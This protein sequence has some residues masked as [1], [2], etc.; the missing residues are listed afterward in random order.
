MDYVYKIGIVGLGYVGLPLALSLS[1]KFKTIGYDINKLR[2][3][4]LKKGQDLTD[5]VKKEEI[6]S[7]VDLSLT[8]KISDLKKCNFFIITVPTPV[9]TFNNPDL[10][11]L[12]NASEEVGKF[13]LKKNDVVVYESTVFPGAT[14]EICAPI[15][16]KFS[17]LK[18]NKDFMVGY[19][20]ERINPGD[21][22]R[23]LENIIKIV[24][25]SNKKAL[26]IIDNVYSS[27]IEAGT[28]RVDLIKEAEA[29]KVIE[30]TQRDINIALFNELAIL[31]R[32]MNLNSKNIFDAASSKW[33]FLRFYPGLV[34]GHCIGV[35]PY[36]L[37]H[38]AKEYNF[39]PSLILAGRKINDFM[40]NHI[41]SEVLSLLIKK[42]I[43][44]NKDSKILIFG[45][46][47]KENCPDY[48]N[49]KVF[50]I[51]NLFKSLG[52]KIDIYDPVIKENSIFHDL[53][54]YNL[55]KK[56]KEKNY[57]ALIICVNHDFFKNMGFAFIKRFMK[58]KSVI[59]DVKRCFESNEIDGYLWWY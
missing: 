38:K 3:S 58:K 52:V 23:K 15:L 40:P 49:S 24:S 53:K 22:D 50:D 7:N 20:P 17:K 9:D 16:E 34:G 39:H 4:D 32:K 46:T 26:S 10:S 35:D 42:N 13:C 48:R 19:S 27:I 12:V 36:Y 59:Y 11:P 54:K 33:N 45:L 6:K 1:K 41:Y 30:N 43:A 29:A 31:F 47:F 55:I 51:V 44:V 56:P 57:D 18:L 37:T 2:I 14:E 5:E 8:H 21:K 25:G 28:Y